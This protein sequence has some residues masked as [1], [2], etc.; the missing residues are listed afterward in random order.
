[1]QAAPNP[2]EP[3][4][5]AAL[6]PAQPLMAINTRQR[7]PPVFAGLRGD[8]VEDWL[9]NYN[10]VSD[11]NRWDTSQKL[12]NV[13]FYLSDVAKTWYWNH[14]PDIPD[15]ATFTEHIRQI[16]G[17]PSVRAEVAKKKLGERIQSIGESYTSY[18]EDVL[19]LCK[20][21]NAT[22]SQTD[23]I[24]HVIKGINTI[25]F[26]ALATQNPATIQEVIAICQRLEDL[27]SL[28]L[29]TDTPEIR[30]P[31]TTDLRTLIRDIVREELHA[32]C[33]SCPTAASIPPSSNTLRDI[34]KQEIASASR[35]TCP[36]SS[37]ARQVPTYADIAALAPCIPA[38]LPTP[39]PQVPVA[40]LS[41]TMRPQS[42]YAAPRP[43]RP[44]CFYCGYRGHISRFCRRRQS[45][46]QRGYIPEERTSTR[47]AGGYQRTSYRYRSP[48]PPYPAAMPTNTRDSRRR[49]PSPRRRSVSPLRPASNIA[50]SRSENSPMQF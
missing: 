19:A 13:P 38:A 15:W 21:V 10:L 20:R 8:D 11:F 25:A 9:K 32:Q 47:P 12:S 44:I 6:Q 41:P 23:Q 46:E 22:M 50:N 28:R 24:R 31:S 26:N 29:S 18:I 5:A 48:S 45:D 35:P 7:D 43:A 3:I 4:A 16:F 42:Y 30:L 33:S 39:A 1:M 2:G 37:C 17:A 34:I 14:E 49:S 40:S 27:Q 36:D